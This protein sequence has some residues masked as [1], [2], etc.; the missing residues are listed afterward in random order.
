MGLLSGHLQVGRCGIPCV[1]ILDVTDAL[2]STISIGRACPVPA[3][4]AASAWVRRQ[5][6]QTL[7][8]V[9]GGSATRLYLSCVLQI[10][11]THAEEYQALFLGVATIFR[12]V[13]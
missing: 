8:R 6:Y 11:S 4:V 2:L 13:C 12:K 1:P 10:V 7:F 3:I 9:I 5:E